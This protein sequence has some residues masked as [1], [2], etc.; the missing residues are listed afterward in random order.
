MVEGTYH[1]A[2][3]ALAPGRYVIDVSVR[4]SSDAVSNPIV[5]LPPDLAAD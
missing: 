4:G 3:G 2:L 1:A 5:V